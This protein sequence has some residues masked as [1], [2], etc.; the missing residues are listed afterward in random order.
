MKKISDILLLLICFSIKADYLKKAEIYSAH[1][2]KKF[3]DDIRIL[4]VRVYALL[5]Q[6]NS[7]GAEELLS[8]TSESSRNL[9]YLRT[10]TAILLSMPADECE[11][12]IR[13]Y[14]SLRNQTRVDSNETR[15]AG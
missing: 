11:S 12:R 4:E 7:V 15:A 2:L 6:G 13:S 14:L 8:T 1:A 9:E 5:L 3:P 10:R